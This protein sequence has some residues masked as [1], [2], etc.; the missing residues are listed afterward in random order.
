[1]LTQNKSTLVQVTVKRVTILQIYGK[2]T[3]M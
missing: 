1:M 2:S 3:E